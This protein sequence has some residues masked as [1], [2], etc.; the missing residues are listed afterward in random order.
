MWIWADKCLET[1]ELCTRRPV[2]RILIDT[3]PCA[4]SR[5]V[6]CLLG[7]ECVRV[8][9]RRFHRLY[10][11]IHTGFRF[12]QW[13]VSQYSVEISNPACK[14]LHHFRTL[15]NL[16]CYWL[17]MPSTDQTFEEY[18]CL[19]T[20]KKQKQMKPNVQWEPVCVSLTK[21]PKYIPP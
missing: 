9:D 15:V 17:H 11:Q 5:T 18:R 14:W 19:K 13:T 1:V 6:C 7:N 10:R 16:E 4:N 21:H 12:L 3:V 2:V 20:S 8:N